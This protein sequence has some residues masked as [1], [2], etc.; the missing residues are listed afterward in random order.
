MLFRAALL[1]SIMVPTVATAATVD[2][3]VHTADGR[4]L[5]DAVVTLTSPK[6][7]AGPIHFPWPM[8]MAQKDIAF[9]PHV[10]IVPV[11]ATV[12]LPN[13]DRVRH[14][15]YSFSKA[16]K[17]DIKLYGR[18]Q[19]RSETFN[20]PGVVALGCNIHDRMSGFIIV[21]KTPYAA[22]TDAQGHVHLTSVPD[23]AAT[24]S[25]WSP[26]I[27]VSGNQV[28]QPVTVTGPTYARTF[29]VRR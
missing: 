22:K 6:A 21:V 18:E 29:T 25:V 27:R 15:V 26:S 4:P 23:G 17:F 7:P 3:T 1:C 19:T 2:I 20:K 8:V 16:K 9:V 11:G 10:L 14:E 12:S 5:A 24:L 13:E 28:S